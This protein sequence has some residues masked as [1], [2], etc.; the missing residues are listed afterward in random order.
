MLEAIVDAWPGGDPVPSGL[1]LAIGRALLRLAGAEPD[2]ER[3]RVNA[4]Q[5][6]VSLE[7][8]A[9]ALLAESAP[10]RATA[11]ALLDQVDALLLTERDWPRAD[12]VIARAR[13]LTDDPELYGACLIRS[14]RL[15]ARRF[16]E[17]GSPSDLAAAAQRFAG[18]SRL[19]SRDRPEYGQLLEEWGALLLQRAG[20]EGGATAISQAVRVLRDCRMET[21]ADDPR[22]PD[23]L[24][25]LGRALA[26]RYQE[27]VDM[28]DL[29]EAEH[30]FTRAATGAE[31]PLTRAWA[32]FELGETHRRAF[33]HIG[34]LERLES[35]AEAYRR[36]AAAAAEA[37]RA[38]RG[39]AESSEAVR[40]GAL[41]LHQRGDAYEH[42]KRPLAAAEAFRAARALWRRL[43]DGGGDDGR[44]TQQRLDEL[45]GGR[46]V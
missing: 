41:A 26:A 3:A 36:S 30:L 43:P 14:A 1:P 35:A 7:L 10:P 37:E 27:A 46:D 19:L 20:L 5:A 25:L 2:A 22:L 8:G 24:L 12:S 15:R 33:R 21:P 18:A 39:G 11:R 28:V 6:A 42:A 40:L 9:Q 29:R 17:H 13:K 4:E 32:W 31:E 38:E 34:R 45:H 16:A 44:A 23:R